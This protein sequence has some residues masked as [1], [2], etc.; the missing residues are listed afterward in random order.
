MRKFFG[1]IQAP[2]TKVI[3]RETSLDEGLTVI[4][5][6]TESGAIEIN[7]RYNDLEDV[8]EYEL[9]Q[10]DEDGEVVVVVNGEI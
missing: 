10:R 7:V 2:N 6:S 1:V 9:T 5:G 4:V 8:D 3:R